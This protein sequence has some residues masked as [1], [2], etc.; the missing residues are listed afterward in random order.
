MYEQ[1]RDQMAGQAFNIES[2]VFALE[3]IKDTQA[4]V[5]MVL[6]LIN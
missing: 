4:T 1:Q 5:S 6:L 2:T 3:S